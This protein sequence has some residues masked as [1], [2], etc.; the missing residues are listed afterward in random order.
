MIA[1]FR[2]PPAPAVSC[3]PIAGPLRAIL[4]QLLDVL[5]ILSRDQYAARMGPLFSDG[6]VG[7]HV[8]HCLDHVRALVDGRGAGIVDYDHRVR[9]TNVETDP[10]AACG[11]LARLIPAIHS[12][13]D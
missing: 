8:R 2:S 11:E 3:A 5:R 4:D 7:G 12:L 13:C 9:G 1:S 6:T 10:S